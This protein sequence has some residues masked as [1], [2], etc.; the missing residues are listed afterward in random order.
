[1]SNT[2]KKAPP[3]FKVGIGIDLGTTNSL[4]TV[5]RDVYIPSEG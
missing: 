5:V 4:A 2:G 3:K 1:M